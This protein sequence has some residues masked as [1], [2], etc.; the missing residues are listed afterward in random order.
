[1]NAITSLTDA[2]REDLSKKNS[3]QNKRSEQNRR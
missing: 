3:E 2:E 1:M